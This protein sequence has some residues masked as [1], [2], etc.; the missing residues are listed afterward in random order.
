[1]S[2]NGRDIAEALAAALAVAGVRTYAYAPDTFAP[3]GIV[4]GSPAMDWQTAERT[5]CSQVWAFPVTVA[6]SRNTDREAQSGLF[7]VVDAIA[8]VL[9][10]DHDLGGLVQTSRLMTAVP[11]TV[12]ANGQEFPAY[13]LTVNVLA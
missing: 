6:V 9:A 5:F 7:D 10:D 11:T 2:V 8:E 12:T 3:P 13:Q 4:V 1:M